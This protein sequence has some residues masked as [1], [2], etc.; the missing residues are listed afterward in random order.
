MLTVSSVY[1]QPCLTLSAHEVQLPSKIAKLYEIQLM[2]GI[3]DLFAKQHYAASTKSHGQI[4]AGH[5]MKCYEST[6]P[7]RTTK[8][9]N[10]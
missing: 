4:I 2:L 5:L 6:F 7:G 3:S 9:K 10:T 1:R 8:K